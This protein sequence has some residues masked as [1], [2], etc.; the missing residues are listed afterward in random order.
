MPA[1]RWA[2]K[3]LAMDRDGNGLFEY[4]ISGN[5]GS[6]SGKA[7]TQRPSQLVGHHRLRP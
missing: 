3:L 2:D 1:S 7:P 5:S 6:W 4:P